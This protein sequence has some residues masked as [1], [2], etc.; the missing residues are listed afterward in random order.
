MSAAEVLFAKALVISRPLTN[1][2]DQVSYAETAQ[3][4]LRLKSIGL[5]LPGSK[6][7]S[8]RDEVIEVNLNILIGGAGQGAIAEYRKLL[9]S[10]ATADNWFADLGV[11]KD[12]S[13]PLLLIGICEAWRRLVLP[14]SS[15]PW[16]LLRVARMD[17]DDALDLVAAL[18]KQ[19]CSCPRCS[20]PMCA[21]A[22]R[23]L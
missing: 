5:E 16:Q 19:H 9:E 7:P 15:L 1:F 22:S 8:S 17:V 13:L 14:Y 10:P 11:S 2:M 18:Q 3:T 21:E 12:D 20:D 23:C 4:R 6:C